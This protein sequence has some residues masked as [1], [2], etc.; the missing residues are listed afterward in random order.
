MYNTTHI[1]ATIVLILYPLFSTYLFLE[2]PKKSKAKHKNQLKHPV[3]ADDDDFK[4]LRRPFNSI[5]DSNNVQSKPKAEKTNRRKAAKGTGEYSY[6]TTTATHFV[7]STDRW[8]ESNQLEMAME[9]SNTLQAMHRTEDVVDTDDEEDEERDVDLNNLHTDIGN[10]DIDDDVFL[11]LSALTSHQEPISQHVDTTQDNHDIKATYPSDD[12]QATEMD[13]ESNSDDDFDFDF[14]DDDDDDDDDDLAVMRDYMENV[15][16]TEEDIL[17]ILD[18]HGDDQD[19][20]DYLDRLD[21]DTLNELDVFLQ[22]HEGLGKEHDYNELD[23]MDDLELLADEEQH[24]TNHGL[25]NGDDDD[26]DEI[27]ADAFRTV[28]EHSLMDVPSGLNQGT[29]NRISDDKKAAKKQKRREKNERKREIKAK[30][31][32][33]EQAKKDQEDAESISILKIDSRIQEFIN[34]DQLDSYQFAPMSRNCRKQ[35]HLLATAYRLKSKSVGSG[36]SRAPIIT[37]T[38]KTSIPKNRRQLDRFIAQAQNNMEAQDNILRKHRLDS[39][40]SSTKG[41]S[42]KSIN[43]GK[44]SQ[45]GGGDLGVS[46]HGSIVALNAAPI[47][48]SNVGHRMLAA[49]GWKEG[50]G[51]GSNQEGITDPIEAVIRGKRRGL[52]T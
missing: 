17:Q 5:N 4:Q 9:S 40:A 6:I 29:Q 12:N 44:K 15:Q 27:S 43:S 49:M 28:L 46:T 48:G 37:K 39:V 50:S 11:Q 13:S 7:Q 21:H 34:D 10:M 35:L 36:K 25:I 51:L 47:T 14:D 31:K 45:A 22:K 42:K 8:N 16:L 2:L 38:D 24:L 41:K 20:F 23:D 52:G 3:L 33:K 1:Y 26:D 30:T 19:L 32:A 18:H